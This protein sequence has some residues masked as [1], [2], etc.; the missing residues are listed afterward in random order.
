MLIVAQRILKL[1]R[2]HPFEYKGA[3]LP[4]TVSFG[5][6]GLQPQMAVVDFVNAADDALFRAKMAGGNRCGIA[7]AKG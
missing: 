6:A 1:I 2:Q 7:G 3:K 4:I 5:A